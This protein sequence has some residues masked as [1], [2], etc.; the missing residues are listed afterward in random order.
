M[1]GLIH[2]G[3]AA[4]LAGFAQVNLSPDGDG[5]RQ[6]YIGLDLFIM[7]ILSIAIDR[8]FCNGIR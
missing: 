8:Y 6:A 7:P 1:D 4:G 5:C 3:W 2:L